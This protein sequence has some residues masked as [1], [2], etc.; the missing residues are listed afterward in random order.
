MILANKKLNQF[1]NILCFHTHLPFTTP[2][3]QIDNNCIREVVKPES[4]YSSSF[5]YYTSRTFPLN[6]I[7]KHL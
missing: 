2:D 4:L 6:T 3:V 1:F 5:P 7:T